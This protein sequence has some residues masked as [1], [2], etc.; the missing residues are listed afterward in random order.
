MTTH[1]RLDPGFP[2]RGWMIAWIVALCAAPVVHGGWNVKSTPTLPPLPVLAPTALTA[3]AGDGH[4]YLRWNPQIEDPRVTGWRVWQLTPRE[5]A[6][7]DVLAEPQYVAT[8]LA[9]GT[10]YT[11]AVTG[12]LKGGGL[13]PRSNPVTVMP[14]NVG[15][16]RVERL[17][18]GPVVIGRQ[19]DVELG[20]DAV[21][22][23][24][25]DGQSLT[26]SDF[27]PID[28]KARDG[29]HLLY[30]RKF[31]NGL[32]I[33][34]FDERG[35]PKIIP[36]DGLKTAP[37]DT[38]A[39]GHMPSAPVSEYRDVQWGSPHPY[40]TDP[41]TQSLPVHGN[42]ARPVWRDPAV[43]GNRVTFHYWLPLTA[44]G[45]RSWTYVLVWDTWWPIERD[46][47][48][49]R[50]HGLARLVEV[51]M[52][53]ALKLGYQVMLNNGF[54]PQGGSREGVVCYSTGFRNPG[55]E[56]VDFSGDKNQ[57]VCFQ[58]RNKPPRRGYGYHPNHDCL[59]ASPLIFYDWGRGSLTIAARSLYYH[60]AN[61]S[62]SYAEQ[63]ADGV[64]P[65]L[66]W[67]MAL[68]GRRP[69]VDTV[70]YLYTG[71]TNQ[72]LPQR[73]INARFEA[74]A[75]VSHRMGVQDTLGAV[76][77]DSPHSQIQREG[78]PEAFAEKYV[79][80][81]ENKGIDVLAMYHDIWHAVPVEVDDAYRLDPTY[82]CNPALRRMCDR[83]RAAGY[84]P[85]FWF[86]PEF[87]KT[88]LVSALSDTIP[89]A[90]IYYG[91]DMCKY[92]DVVKLLHE[93]GIP[94]FREHPEWVR[95]NRD[96]SWP[97]NPPYQWV[98][99]SLAGGWWDRIM[100]PT[101]N[102]SAQL[103]FQRVLVDGGFGGLQGV[104]YAP[105]LA[106]AADGA[107][108]CQPYW[109]RM[110]R[111]MEHVGIRMFGECTV[112]WKGGNVTAGGPGDENF[113]W[114]FHMGW[115]IGVSGA[116]QKPEETHRLY[117][118]YNT[119]RGDGANDAVRRYARRF[120]ESHP[121]P[122]WIEFQGLRQV[123]PVEV[124]FKPGDSPVA[125]GDTRVSEDGQV[126]IRVRPW[127]WSDVVWHYDDGRE[128]VY[129][130]FDRVDWGKE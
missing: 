102:M 1:R 122:D 53:G 123:E 81:L 129:P 23:T 19:K 72:P 30:P 69:A 25:P 88:S 83:I 56:V 49:T 7:A 36:P 26:Y 91:Y 121:A 8:G 12:V 2:L 95:R 70:E 60:A 11:F 29:E 110:W 93:R 45:Y 99:M 90:E 73:Y 34:Q 74:Y 33:G 92:P 4:A 66:A 27:R 94:L 68:A 80:R 79:K 130:A 96:G 108:P 55:A 84:K 71:E 15:T 103:G 54:G 43:D 87:T 113:L 75:D 101:L 17:P 85:G 128:A 116:L 65:N 111:T 62:S 67:D 61:N 14:Q 40:I 10:S 58:H 32:D 59:Q 57:G 44:M 115:Y 3:D 104:D 117:Q 107:V 6:I 120:Y 46:R 78:G 112:G 77:M 106:G 76:A 21:R 125:G 9:N 119:N 42:D 18:A 37:A 47:H 118:L 114:M 98:P 20:A 127:T 22:V 5:K 82:D 126:T 28:W 48:G 63:G 51:Q 13:T 97:V 38:N 109:W 35:L 31:G 105:M 16:A 64:W 41:L 39:P 124:T 100:W 52:P 24:F 50:Y 89:T 86:R